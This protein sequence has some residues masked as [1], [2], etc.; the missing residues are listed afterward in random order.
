MITRGYVCIVTARPYC[1]ICM[2]VHC[3]NGAVNMK[4]GFERGLGKYGIATL[5]EVVIAF[6][7][8]SKITQR[9]FWAF[10]SFYYDTLN[11]VLKIIYAT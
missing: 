9:H 8:H 7:I 4:S 5:V 1:P 10:P 11:K 6:Y 2:N 3:G